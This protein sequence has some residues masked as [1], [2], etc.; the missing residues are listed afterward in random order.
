MYY[1]SSCDIGKRKSEQ[2]ERLPP[3]EA[4]VNEDSVSVLSFTDN[5]RDTNREVGLFVLADGAGGEDAG[6][7]A[8]Y[9]ATSTISKHLSEYVVD[10]LA[11]NPDGVGV[12]FPERILDTGDER[13]PTAAIDDAVQAAQRRIIEYARASE[14]DDVDPNNPFRAYTTVVA[15][16]YDGNRLHYGWVGDSRAYVVNTAA[17]RISPLTKDHSEVQ[18]LLD[19]GAISE[20]E[21]MVH[22]NSNLIQRAVGGTSL[23]DPT[24]GVEVDTDSVSLYEDDVVLFTSD[25]L[26]DAYPDIDSLNRQYQAAYGDQVEDVAQTI[27]ET[28]VTDDDIREIV[29]SSD[30]L[31]AAA[32]RFIEFSNEKGGK[33]NI[34]VI[35]AS[36]SDLPPTPEDLPARGFEES[37]EADPAADVAQRETTILTAE[38][39]TAGATE[40]QS[41]PAPDSAGDSTGESGGSDEAPQGN[42][43][44]VR[45]AS[46][47][48]SYVVADGETIGRSR[49]ADVEVG[50]LTDA[51]RVHA[52]V[53]VTDDGVVFLDRSM[54]GTYYCHSSNDEWERVR[55]TETPVLRDGDVIALGDVA[56]ENVFTIE[57]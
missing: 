51:S 46:V 43:S 31:D 55:E 42:G 33:D 25:G 39:E 23:S 19:A 34:A 13:S 27:R 53:S 35:L 36:G 12:D 10:R 22:T 6:D 28:V 47:S 21:G 11:G 37:A 16:I 48:E 41:D 3:A 38:D 26:I 8:S 9:L 7:V 44:L 56:E 29:V 2:N 40:S 20:V 32:E 18:Q 24:D 1:T 30:S 17:E 14:P 50:A 49:R 52:Q 54:N 57:L 15:G 5:H 4:Y 45:L